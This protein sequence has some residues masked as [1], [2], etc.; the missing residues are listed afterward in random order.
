MGVVVRSLRPPR[1]PRWTVIW[2]KQPTVDE[3]MECPGVPV[4]WHFPEQ[5]TL[6][7]LRPPLFLSE[8]SVQH[9]CRGY[10]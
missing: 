2:S 8:A 9:G 10:S 6:I 3:I 7:A 5:G 4:C 1:V